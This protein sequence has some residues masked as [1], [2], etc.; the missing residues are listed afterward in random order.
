MDRSYITKE[1]L[2]FWRA[3]ASKRPARPAP[4]ISTCGALLSKLIDAGMTVYGVWSENLEELKRVVREVK[5]GRKG[6]EGE[7]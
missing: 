4:T 5:C 6:E 7:E 1:M 2:A 3:M